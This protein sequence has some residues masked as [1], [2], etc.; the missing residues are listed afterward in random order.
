MLGIAAIMMVQLVT[1]NPLV[2]AQ[3]QSSPQTAANPNILPS[4]TRLA[5]LGDMWWAMGL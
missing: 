5:K 2:L 4:N 3:S 1:L